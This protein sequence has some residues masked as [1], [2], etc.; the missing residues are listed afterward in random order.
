MHAEGKKDLTACMIGIINREFFSRV[1]YLVDLYIH[2]LC[3]VSGSIEQ[4]KN[5]LDGCLLT[6]WLAN[7]YTCT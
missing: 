6:E 7:S 4:S 1:H 2:V 5:N 3:K